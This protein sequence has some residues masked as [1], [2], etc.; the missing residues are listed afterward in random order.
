M[1]PRIVLDPQLGLGSVALALVFAASFAAP[2]EALTGWLAAFVLQSAPVL[3][4]LFFLML[5][6]VIPGFWRTVIRPPASLLAG[7]MPVLAL[8]V[9]PVLLGMKAIFPWYSGEGLSGFQADYLTPLGLAAR[10]VVFVGGGV[11][12]AFHLSRGQHRAL[13]IGGLVFFVLLDGFFATDLVLS[14]DPKFH[15]SG[16]GLYFL[17]IQTLTA[18]AAIV[19][20]RCLRSSPAAS[21]KSLLGSLFLTFLLCWAYFDFMQYF[22]LW[23]GNLPARAAWFARRSEGAWYWLVLILLTLRLVPAFLLL[24]P[25]V[26][27]NGR[28]L[29]FFAALTLAGTFLE[30]GWLVLPELDRP[31]W[32]WPS[33]AAASAGMALVVFGLGSDGRG[34]ARR[35]EQDAHE[36]T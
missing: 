30:I 1:K 15:S 16:F 8:L 2:R 25:P 28:W 18:F 33:Y 19:L 9:L 6:D 26:R 36:S 29:I 31:A 14:L 7:L 21:E 23:S 11:W 12:I 22:I 3:G 34:T 4:G 27:Q 17:A 35:Q 5:A 24:F 32:A 13:A 20:I 10:L